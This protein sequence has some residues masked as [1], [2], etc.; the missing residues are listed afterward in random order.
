MKILLLRN[1]VIDN[2]ILDQ[3][4]ALVK[5][6]LTSIGFPIEIPEQVVTNQFTGLATKN[7]E[8][9]DVVLIPPS[10][11]ASFKGSNDAVILIFDADKVS[12]R[13]TNPADNEAIMQIPC[14]WFTGTAQ[15]FCDY[16]LHELCHLLFAKAGQ[17]DITHLAVN[18]DSNPTLY[19]QL[20]IGNKPIVEFYIYL[21]NS[22]KNVW[23]TNN[24]R[25]L[26]LGDTGNG[27]KELQKLLGITADGSFG[28]ITKRVVVAFQ[29]SRKL[30]GDGVVGP[31]TWAEL[32]KKSKLTLIE[33]IIQVESSGNDNAIGDK[34]LK[35]PAYGPMQIRQPVCIDVNKK[36]S[37]NYKAIDC[38]GNRNLS[39]DIWNKYQSIY[40]PQGSNEEKSRT[41]NGGPGWKLRPHLTDEYWNKVK[42]LLQ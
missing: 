42:N 27:V 16:F 10:Q 20:N 13:P 40:N 6:T 4:I 11:I 9:K 8:N 32:K 7:A 1:N 17:H 37:T 35:Y 36:F 21:I 23:G 38:L 2:A 3:G 29:L 5:Q 14:Q 28:P 31:K 34:L 12:P 15:G 18:R 26:R 24:Q 22:L 33:A 19:D 41:W 25:T 39:I 30:L